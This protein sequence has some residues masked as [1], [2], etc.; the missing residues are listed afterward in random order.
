MNLW[1]LW[2]FIL[3]AQNFAFTFVSRAR[4]SGS[5]KRH[6]IAAVFSNGVWFIS[7]TIIFSKLFE[8]ISG[9]HGLLW[10]AAVGL[11]YTLFTIIGSVSA[12]YFS[13]ANEKGKTAVG[14]T[15]K[16]AQITPEQWNEVLKA[17]GII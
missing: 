11:Y 13:L 16:Y 14:A 3:I 9:K 4:N 17:I 7:Q 10:A 5:I 6:V 1:V 15:K 8:Y 2:A 12:H